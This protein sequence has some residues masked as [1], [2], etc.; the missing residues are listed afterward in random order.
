[1]VTLEDPFRI[2]SRFGSPKD[3]GCHCI[4]L[5]RVTV[6]AE[7]AKAVAIQGPNKV[8]VQTDL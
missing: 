5:R 2:V 1:V 3:H 6:L 8:K 4:T 7:R